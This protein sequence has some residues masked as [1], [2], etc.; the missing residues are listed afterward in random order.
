MTLNIH[1][2]LIVMLNSENIKNDTNDILVDVFICKY[3][4]S[5]IFICL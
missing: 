5:N 3:V 4:D 1:K 2:Y